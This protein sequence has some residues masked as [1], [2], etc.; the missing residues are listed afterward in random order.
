[1]RI[2]NVK[3]RIHSVG[4][5]AEAPTIAVSGQPLLVLLKGM[6]K[7]ACGGVHATHCSALVSQQRDISCQPLR[8]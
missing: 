6:G 1:V 5:K 3:L 2:V 7:V 8:R 4:G